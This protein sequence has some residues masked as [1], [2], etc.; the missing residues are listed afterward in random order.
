MKSFGMLSR[1]SSWVEWRCQPRRR[2]AARWI[3]VVLCGAALAASIAGDGLARDESAGLRAVLPVAEQAY[4]FLHENPELGKAEHKA[5]AY[6]TQQLAAIGG[7]ELVKSTLAP[8][9]VIAVFD[10]GRAGPVV[11]LRAEMDAR[12]LDQGVNEPAGDDPR[13]RTDG[14]MHNCGHDLH[15]AILLA[16]AKYI[17]G[18]QGGFS[19]KIVFLFQPAE[20]VAGGADDIVREGI[21][22]RL[23]VERIFALHAAPGMPVGTIAI[24]AGAA[25]AGSSTFTL[26]LKGRG[27]HAA[28][29]FEGDDLPV[30]ASHF[31]HALTSFP[32][33]RLDLANRPVVI[34]VARLVSESSAS[35]MTPQSAELGGTIRAFEDVNVAPPDGP[36]I[37]AML[38]DTVQALAKLHGVSAE[39]KL[40]PG[41][42][43]TVNHLALFNQ[44]IPALRAAWPG[45][46]ETKPWR[47]MFSED[48]AYYT[49][50]HPS[51]YFSLGIAKDGLGKVGVHQVEFTVHPDS[52]MSGLQL[53]TS[54][55]RIATAGAASP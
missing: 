26:S 10:T 35:N 16:S 11:A 27:S 48:F 33:R 49:A 1:K 46:L 8:T 3:A 5:H 53:M 54:L 39:W 6:L 47:G 31:V 45:T 28:A 51:L 34:S 42:P 29:P 17:A 4:R 18:N 37:A 2:V 14:V 25:L 21:L 24:S 7:L 36:S 44:V 9:A 20:E 12:K 23:K 32:A 50:R 43:M 55:A 38:S 22:E 30:V 40:R 52:L 13:S 19:G 41:A 15:A